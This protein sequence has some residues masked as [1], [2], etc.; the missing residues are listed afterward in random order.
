MDWERQNERQRLL[1]AKARVERELQE[2]V[3]A[4]RRLDGKEGLVVAAASPPAPTDPVVVVY[5]DGGCVGNQQRDMSVRIMRA[6]VTDDCGQVRC[7]STLR[8]GSNNIAE[9]WAL[10]E[11]LAWLAQ[12]GHRRALIRTDSRNLLA[13]AIRP[14]RAGVND[15]QAVLDLQ[16]QLA[17]WSSAVSYR[18]E[19][20]PRAENKAGIYLEK[21]PA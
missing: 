10:V 16:V 19:W 17:R 7:D 14:P 6:V 21:H 13:W 11:A 1:D 12:Q 3:L 20:V 15:R 5:V 8:G 18:L 2:I 4:L 9:L